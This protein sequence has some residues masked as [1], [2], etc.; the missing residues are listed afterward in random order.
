MRTRALHYT[1]CIWRCSPVNARCITRTCHSRATLH[2]H[3]LINAQMG[4]VELRAARPC[5]PGHAHRL[6]TLRSNFNKMK[7]WAFGKRIITPTSILLVCW[8]INQ[9]LFWCTCCEALSGLLSVLCDFT[10][11]INT[12]LFS[13]QGGSL[14]LSQREQFF[15]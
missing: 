11:V 12:D 13:P 5:R 1:F 14:D 10:G 15:L 2:I 7:I 8:F 4:G 9:H 6:L 3:T